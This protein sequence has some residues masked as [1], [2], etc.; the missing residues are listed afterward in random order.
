MKPIAASTG[1]K[2]YA[3]NDRGLAEQS[4]VE[5]AKDLLVQAGGAF[6]GYVV[7]L[8]I[9]VVAGTLGLSVR[10]RRRDLA[11][12]R[13]VAAT[14]GQIRKLLLAEAVVV[15]LVAAVI[16]IPAGLAAT[17][18]AEHQL[19]SRGFIPAGFP[20]VDAVNFGLGAA[21]AT[22]ATL[23]VAVLAALI[24]ARRVAGIKPVEALGEVAV[25][26]P[27]SGKVRLVSGLLALL[28]GVSASGFALAATGETALTGALGMLYLFVLAVGLLAPWINAAAARLLSPALRLLWG[29]SGYLATANLKANARG[30]ATVLTALVLAVGFGGSVWFLQDNLQRQTVTQTRDG[31]LA[32][33]ALVSPTGL[34]DAA[35]DELRR[36]SGVQQVTAVRHT[37]VVV[38][39]LG[40]LESVDAQAIG[41]ADKT[42]DLDVRSGNLSDLRAGTVAVSSMRAGTGRWKVGDKVPLWLGDGTRTTLKLVAVYQR[43]LGF[44]DVILPLDA[45][46]GLADELLVSS[47]PGADLAAVTKNHPGSSVV[48]TQALSGKL[49]Q[50]L[51]VS[52]WLNRML[53][54]VMV[55]YAAL[56]A[57][58]TM[59]I[60]ALAR[61]RELALLRLVGVTRRQVKR[62]VHAEQVGLLGVALVI[63]GV[64]AA[65]TLTAVVIGLT[66]KPVPYV[67]PLGW[68]AVIGGA[69]LL[70]LLTTVYPIG[71]LLR[72][73]PTEHMA[74]KE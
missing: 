29:N 53:I 62:M 52:A 66:G 54:G 70:A 41:P 56:A 51:A 18:W 67:P 65:V 22:L 72:A 63:G 50:D 40:D 38:K 7:M 11:L 57:A 58:N 68:V 26:A 43:G 17:A 5:D 10:H 21:A 12:L 45:A 36:V 19:T 15:S 60:A 44:G 16:G 30:M 59:V 46:P 42:L 25:E 48:S 47:R 6:G 4:T 69:T 55:G 73:S 2:V 32:Q 49:A 27:P 39:A 1:A 23:I 14:P 64:I 20:I 34:P 24:A 61:R 37:K 9:F 31:T 71:R 35:A 74:I 13:A 8:V 3:G 28:A 33:H